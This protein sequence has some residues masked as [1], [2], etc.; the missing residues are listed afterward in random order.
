MAKIFVIGDREKNEWVSVFDA[1]QKQMAFNNDLE[2]AKTF[3]AL[4]EAK[5][6]LAKMQET[7]YFFDLQVY[8]KEA[9]GK[10]YTAFERDSFHV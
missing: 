6:A 5:A 7:G 4:D 2:A 10:A 9:D 8:L 1:S 3:N